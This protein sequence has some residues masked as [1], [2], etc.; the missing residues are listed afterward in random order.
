MSWPNS[1]IKF[2]GSNI[3]KYQLSKCIFCDELQVC[4]RG[5]V[6]SVTFSQGGTYYTGT[7]PTT[8][9]YVALN[10]GTSQYRRRMHIAEVHKKQLNKHNTA[11][12]NHCYIAVCRILLSVYETVMILWNCVTFQYSVRNHQFHNLHKQWVPAAYFL[13]FKV[14]LQLWCYSQSIT[15]WYISYRLGF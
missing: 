10:K 11:N 15:Y 6:I 5:I 1:N 9:S 4:N 13:Y 12:P 14:N 8:W 2:A 3:I 7:C